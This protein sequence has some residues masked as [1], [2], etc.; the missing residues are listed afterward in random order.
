MCLSVFACPA[1]PSEKLSQCR[2]GENGREKGPCSACL[3][4]HRPNPRLITAAFG[5]PPISWPGAATTPMPSSST[6]V[7]STCCT[8]ATAG[9]QACRGVG[10]GRVVTRTRVTGHT[11]KKQQKKHGLSYSVSRSLPVVERDGVRVV[12]QAVRAA[13]AAEGAVLEDAAAVEDVDVVPERGKRRGE[14]RKDAKNRAQHRI[15]H[16]SAS[17]QNGDF[18]G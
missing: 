12:E 17:N 6:A 16:Q 2:L 14:R 13:P 7:S 3:S 5:L 8:S 11:L 9:R 18:L 15:E 4:L 1:Q 10:G